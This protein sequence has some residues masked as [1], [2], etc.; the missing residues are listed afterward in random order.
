MVIKETSVARLAAVWQ[1]L[2]WGSKAV[3]DGEVILGKCSDAQLTWSVQGIGV[4]GSLGSV[5]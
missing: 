2:S 4:S 3:Q 1:S 5:L